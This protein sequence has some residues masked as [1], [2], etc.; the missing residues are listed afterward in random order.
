MNPWAEQLRDAI[1]SNSAIRE[2]IQDDAAQPLIDWGLQ[3]AEQV[4][5]RLPSMPDSIVEQRFEALSAALPKLLTRITWVVVHR[6][7]KGA[8]WTSRT[9]TQLNELNQTLHGTNA[10]QIDE[11]RI[12][13]LANRQDG[14]EPAALISDLIAVL[15]PQPENGEITYDEA[16]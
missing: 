13:Q 11:A 4:T 5:A 9:L 14:L 3:L 2:G 12:A 16:P 8:D 7:K 15:S 10:P 1:L 6:E